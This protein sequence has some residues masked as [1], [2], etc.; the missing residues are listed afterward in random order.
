MNVD[1]ILKEVE[2][3][4]M[5]TI[6]TFTNQGGYVAKFQVWYKDKNGASKQQKVSSVPVGQ[7]KDITIEAGSSDLRVKG[8]AAVFLGTWSTIFND[9]MKVPV[10]TEYISYGTTLNRKWKKEMK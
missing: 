2:D 10:S 1:D 9:S 3:E 7:S 5:D 4:T 8:E 6:I